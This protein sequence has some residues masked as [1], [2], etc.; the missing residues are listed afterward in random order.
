METDSAQL[1]RVA[2][3]DDH[4]M[5]VESL[6]KIINESG[7]AVVVSQYYDLTSCR[8]NLV[9]SLPEVLLLDI[10]LPDGDG[11]DFCAEILRIYPKL[12]I[13]ILT[14]FA[15][16]NIVKHALRNGAL[17]YI[18]KNS[19]AEEI[20]EGIQT[21][22]TGEQFFSKGIDVLLK[23]NRNKDEIVLT[24][25]EKEILKY[26]ADGYTVNKIAEKICRTTEAVKSCRKN[27]FIK[28]DVDN[29]A[30]LTKKALETRS[31]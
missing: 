22:S 27:L 15:E 3:V 19:K 17:G 9:K 30:E 21:V 20:F 4:E 10:A 29:M 11:V 8:E 1:I 28:F 24:N 18:L 2:I 7:I 6:S 13:I 12:K 23:E 26:I 16:F 14:G 25:R 5:V 31:I